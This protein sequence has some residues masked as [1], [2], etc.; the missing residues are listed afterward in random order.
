MWGSFI[1][2]FPANAAMAIANRGR[3]TEKDRRP[4]YRAYPPISYHI[5][6]LWI[7]SAAHARG[8]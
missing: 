4:A 1:G 8:R 5:W 2:E 7:N 6:G 3:I